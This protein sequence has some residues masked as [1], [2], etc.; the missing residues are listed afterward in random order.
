LFLGQFSRLGAW[1]QVLA[2]IVILTLIQLLGN[3]T[4]G[5]ALR[6]PDAALL[7]FVPVLAGL[8]AVALM[9]WWAARRRAH[10]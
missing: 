5:I 4:A 8:G 2:A 7:A 9:L 1:R 3:A 6:R 10:S